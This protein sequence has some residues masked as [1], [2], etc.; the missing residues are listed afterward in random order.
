M[1]QSENHAECKNNT[2]VSETDSNDVKNYLLFCSMFGLTQITKSP[3]LITCSSTSLTDHILASLLATIFVERIIDVDLSDHQLIYYSRKI[4]RINTR[5]LKNNNNNNNNNDN[6]NNNNNNNNGNNN[7]QV[8]ARMK[9]NK[10]VCKV[11][12]ECF[13]RRKPYDEEG[14]PVR[15]CKQRMFRGWRDRGLFESTEQRVGDQAREIMK[16]GWL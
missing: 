10:E 8:T 6:N 9:W 3:T 14:K 5:G 11:V 1:Y 15:G 4:S 12:M 16:N 2:L 7:N 13:Y